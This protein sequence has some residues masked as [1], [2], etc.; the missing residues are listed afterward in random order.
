M[1]QSTSQSSVDT[2]YEPTSLANQAKEFFK[3][4]DH[5]LYVHTFVTHRCFSQISSINLGRGRIVPHCPQGMLVHKSVK[6]RMEKMKGYLPRALVPIRALQEGG[7]EWEEAKGWKV[8][9]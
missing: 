5:Y 4:K 1:E 3:W 9:W 8:V 7:D 2:E 6:T